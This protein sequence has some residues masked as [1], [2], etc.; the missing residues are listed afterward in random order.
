METRIDWKRVNGDA[1][2]GFLAASKSVTSLDAK[3][4]HLIELRVSQVNGCAFCLDMHA[5]DARAAGETAQR[6]DCLAGWREYPWFTPAERAALEWAEALTRIAE[7][8]ADD[9]SYARLKAQFSEKEIVDL[10]V[11]ITVINA[12]NRMQVSMRIPPPSR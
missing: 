5:R 1:Y 11:A 8:R 10:T 2:A 7:E 9:A 6:L 12:W 3:L 4:V